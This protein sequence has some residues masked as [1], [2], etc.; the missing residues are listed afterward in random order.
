MVGNTD[1]DIKQHPVDVLARV[2][3]SGV[4]GSDVRVTLALRPMGARGDGV[5]QLETWPTD[6]EKHFV[7]TPPKL[8]LRFPS[9]SDPDLAACPDTCGATSEF[10]QLKAWPNR[11]NPVPAQRIWH[12]VIPSASASWT[13][14]H[15]GLDTLDKLGL[16][17][18]QEQTPVCMSGRQGEMVL[19]VKMLRAIET[20][21]LAVAEK[22]DM[23]SAELASIAWKSARNFL[24]A[25]EHNP[26]LDQIYPK[27]LEEG[28]GVPKK[29]T[30][31]KD[32]TT[33]LNIDQT[34]L[35]RDYALALFNKV[36]DA[37]SAAREVG[38][39]CV[40]SSPWEAAKVLIASKVDRLI[41][42]VSCLLLDKEHAAD[43]KID[44]LYRRLFDLRQFFL[45]AAALDSDA[46]EKLETSENDRQPI[47]DQPPPKHPVDQCKAAVGQGEIGLAIDAA[48]TRIVSIEE[49]PDLGRLFRFFVDF[50]LPE[51]ELLD[52]V[53]RCRPHEN[54][55]FALMR[56][57]E[58]S[59]L[60]TSTTEDLARWTLVK[61]RL[62]AESGI[63]SFLPASREELLLAC[64]PSAHGQEHEVLQQMDGIYLLGGSYVGID[65]TPAAGLAA[66]PLPAYELV[67]AD[68]RS[69]AREVDSRADRLLSAAAIGGDDPPA[70]III[71]AKS[72]LRSGGLSVVN[73]NA[74]AR[75]SHMIGTA[76]ASQQRACGATFLDAEEL[77]MGRLPMFGIQT[78]VGDDAPHTWHMQTRKHVTYLP[79]NMERGK[80]I[81]VDK[82]IGQLYP[83][84]G[85]APDDPDGPRRLAQATPDRTSPRVFNIATKE[86]TVS[87][88][89]SV[90]AAELT[91]LGDPMGTETGLEDS[92]QFID[93]KSNDLLLDREIK[94]FT[95]GGEVSDTECVLPIRFGM[96]VLC[97]FSVLYLGGATATP[98]EVT[99]R[100]RELPAATVPRKT[101]GKLPK[102]RRYLRS[103]PVAP[104]QILIPKSEADLEVA[105]YRSGRAPDFA[106]QT[107]GQVVLRTELDAKGNVTGTI[108]PTT[109]TRI[110]LPPLCNL[111]LVENHGAFDSRRPR[112]FPSKG[113]DY[114]LEDVKDIPLFPGAYDKPGLSTRPK[115]GLKKIHVDAGFG[116][117]PLLRR[118]LGSASDRPA[119]VSASFDD[120]KAWLEQMRRWA[121]LSEKERVGK[122]APT[123]P[124]GD[125]VF[126][127]ISAKTVDQGRTVPF[128]PDP[129]AAMIVIRL[130]TG[131]DPMSRDCLGR[132]EVSIVNPQTW[133]DVKPLAVVIGG[134][135]DGH[136]VI[137]IGGMVTI[138]DQECQ[139]IKVNLPQGVSGTL[140]FWCVP[141]V[142]QLA[143]WSELVDTVTSMDCLPD[144][145]GP[146]VPGLYGCGLLGMD[147]PN[148][149]RLEQVARRFHEELLIH[150]LPELSE[151][152]SIVVAHATSRPTSMIA[153]PADLIGPRLALRRATAGSVVADL[154]APL[155][156]ERQDELPPSWFTEPPVN[157]NDADL[158]G[159]IG[160][161][162]AST[163]SVEISVLAVAPFGT[164]FDDVKRNRS[165]ADVNAGRVSNVL[166]RKT[167]LM[168]APSDLDIYGFSVSPQGRVQ[169]P[170]TEQ[171]W[172]RFTNLPST[173]GN[174]DPAKPA[175]L[176]LH[177]LFGG[178]PGD[179]VADIRPLFADTRARQVQLKFTAISRHSG[180]FVKR[181]RIRKGEHIQGTPPTPEDTALT[182]E[183]FSRCI[184]LPASARP[185]VPVS[186]AQAH[187]L[188]YDV[189]ET[190]GKPYPVITKTRLTRVRLWL[191][192]PWFTSGEGEKLGIV[193][194]PRLSR[195]RKKHLLNPLQTKALYER[196]SLDATPVSGP[197]V[198]T[199]YMVLERFEE[200]FL[201]GAARY[202]TRWGSDPTE[203]FPSTGWK[204]WVVPYEIF[205]DF[206]FDMEKGTARHLRPDAGFVEK[207]AMPIPETDKQSKPPSGSTEEPW[208]QRYLNVD[209]LTYQPRFDV[210]RE[211]WYVDL[212][213]DAGQ[214]ISP[215]L[216]LGV[217]RYQEHAPRDLQV[218]LPAEPY[219]LQMA[220]YRQSCLELCPDPTD[221][222]RIQ[223]RVTITGPATSDD[224]KDTGP[225]ADAKVE[226]RM[227][228]R[229]QGCVKETGI[230][231]FSSEMEV[232]CAAGGGRWSGKFILPRVAIG[233][234][235]LDLTVQIE[236]LA[237]RPPAT[238]P[239]AYFQ[240]ER[241]KVE[242]DFRVASPR[243]MCA[244]EVPR[245][246]PTPK[247]VG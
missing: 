224:P 55:V 48:R 136:P 107:T 242:N 153:V 88:V 83:D 68:L 161:N 77:S 20:A 146:S 21:Q 25:A 110:V 140:D 86:S 123:S 158:G 46:L 127:P 105:A 89:A 5:A 111:E 196:P 182:P 236:E 157:A 203:A 96:P 185:A 39:K 174:P 120:G 240:S 115:D 207:V 168:R 134:P 13:T 40:E 113:G 103:E 128:Y 10:L 218:S 197:P 213:L 220:T 137:E 125:A 17:A 35:K 183:T 247:R 64:V 246:S 231:R 148:E 212:Q 204:D 241:S 244:L 70:G 169:L 56:I 42:R 233:N 63:A 194:W 138:S 159:F 118:D 135:R 31:G 150:P 98:D 172:A 59:L 108:G 232:R 109:I 147:A 223:L 173:I 217:V 235:E 129:M 149:T 216:R 167:G 238:Y 178:K 14:I 15:C 219:E 27:T 165:H 189:E 7:K 80:K 91:F 72:G 163:S 155:W 22:P 53:K 206:E 49:S 144:V 131:A 139:Q 54:T 171:L 23:R 210:D 205:R 19:L 187:P 237:Y 34:R 112:S 239:D 188:I 62:G 202:I 2:I 58:P 50:R 9:L 126:A 151:V 193:L 130:R 79:R 66:L 166:D 78:G 81:D 133:P 132:H 176:A 245:L 11:S 124:V 101:N 52:L 175:W 191:T 106:P 164:E 1:P 24:F 225:F 41:D 38:S 33:R 214:M 170:Q 181:P 3:P 44:A 209:L 26:L 201:T 85:K 28:I 16:A 117:Y 65:P 57:A 93:D 32:R 74:A 60:T 121:R 47:P 154:G 61:I 152:K 84:A 116:G 119:I 30:A 122:S 228:I 162:L 4:L 184:W 67:S 211:Q 145:I 179:I 29:T 221:A 104:P 180:A 6:I 192:R 199:D 243:Y 215:F 12:E 45:L 226:T 36:A 82:L 177:A 198:R 90:D 208:R 37:C 200:R 97:G 142:A 43:Q 102:G 141:S 160:V 230:P 95:F 195:L 186:A 190:T 92:I 8:E 76:Q 73:F 234:P 229:L 99:D 143:Q 114:P 69:A 94:L 156:M 227:L 100:F 222:D 75:V 71:R 87:L 51:A 18:P